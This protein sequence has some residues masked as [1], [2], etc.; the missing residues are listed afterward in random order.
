M[1]IVSNYCLHFF[2]STC[3]LV[4][5]SY[6]IR[7]SFFVQWTVANAG[8]QIWS[9]CRESNV[10]GVLIHKWDVCNIHSL[11]WNW[12]KEVRQDFKSQRLWGTG[13]K[14][15]HLDTT[16]PQPSDI[17]API[18]CTVLSLYRREGSS[19]APTPNWGAKDN[20]SRHCSVSMWFLTSGPHTSGW[21]RIQE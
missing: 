5:I 10:T 2:P 17:T 8:T 1:G 15:C 4:H 13:S 9:M 21:P 20:R 14:Q 3:R 18:V 7:G 6:L 11:S 16:G 12:S 19:W